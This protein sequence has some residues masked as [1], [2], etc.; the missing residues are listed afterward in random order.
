[1]KERVSSEEAK[2]IAR[3]EFYAASSR[4]GILAL[5]L[6]DAREALRLANV[7]AANETARASDLERE[8]DEAR[9]ALEWLEERYPIGV[10][11]ALEA[12]RTA[13]AA[14]EDKT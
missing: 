14:E 13:A 6:L 12:V 9:A 2:K 4:V 1:M 5:D 10:S 11:R 7:D 3:G 8:R